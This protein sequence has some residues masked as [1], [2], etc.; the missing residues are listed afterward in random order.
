MVLLTGK[1][2]VA[3]AAMPELAQAVEE[4]DG[5]TL[6]Y[7]PDEKGP[8]PIPTQFEVTLYV[9]QD[10]YDA[11]LEAV[12]PWLPGIVLEELEERDWVAENQASFPPLSIGPWRIV[13]NEGEKKGENELLIIPA[14]AFGSGEHATT[15]QCLHHY[16]K[17]VDEGKTFARGLDVGSG[18][19]ILALAA[20]A[21]QG[22]LFVGIDIEEP[23]VIATKRNAVEN[24]LGHL[25]ES[26]LGTVP[27]ALATGD[28][29]LVFANILLGPLMELAEPLVAQVG[30]GGYLILSGFTEAQAVQIEARY[31]PLGLR[32]SHHTVQDGWGCQTWTRAAA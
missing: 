11:S 6:V 16:K 32:L 4:L 18:S 24:G 31:A 29:P 27:H 5:V 30:V 3:A 12:R 2:V 22:I 8:N 17:L 13:R 25:I 14:H 9:Q 1:G 19:G 28:Y 26:G 21:M 7:E 15:Q 10:A 23:S 20:A